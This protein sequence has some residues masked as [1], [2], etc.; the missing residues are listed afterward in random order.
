MSRP[1]KC[2]PQVEEVRPYVEGVAKN[3]VANWL[4]GIPFIQMTMTRQLLGG[5]TWTRN[6]LWTAVPARRTRR[7]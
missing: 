1:K 3:L 2:T 5:A 7:T 6:H 4:S